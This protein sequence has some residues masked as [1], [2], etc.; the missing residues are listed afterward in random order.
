MYWKRPVASVFPTRPDGA[1]LYPRPTT[2]LSM[3]TPDNGAATGGVPP[4][5]PPP[6]SPQAAKN[7]A[8]P[9]ISTALIV[10]DFMACPPGCSLTQCPHRL[11]FLMSNPQARLFQKLFH[12]HLPHARRTNPSL[13]LRTHPS[14]PTFITPNFLFF[15][16]NQMN[17][18]QSIEPNQIHRAV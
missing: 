16:P 11:P 6:P 3:N 17:R 15:P 2:G 9:T 13:S 1:A 4:P 10:P 8:A 7:I 14:P 12:H 18:I 5:P